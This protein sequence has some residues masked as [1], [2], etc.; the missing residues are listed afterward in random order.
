[1]K[2]IK[3]NVNILIFINLGDII[4]LEDQEMAVSSSNFDNCILW[5]ACCTDQLPW[6]PRQGTLSRDSDA[7]KKSFR[8]KTSTL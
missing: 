2:R 6:I 7:W 4:Y 5:A 1:M 8:R 3:E